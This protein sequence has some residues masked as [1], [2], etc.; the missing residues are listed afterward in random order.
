MTHNR[1]S[2]CGQGG[3]S[4]IVRKESA[5][6]ACLSD[7]GV[8]ARTRLHTK[9]SACVGLDLSHHRILSVRNARCFFRIR[10]TDQYVRHATVN[11]RHITAKLRCRQKSTHGKAE[12]H[13][14]VSAQPDN[15]VVRDV[16]TRH[17]RSEWSILSINGTHRSS[18]RTS[19]SPI[20]FCNRRVP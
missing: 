11:V 16:L 10:N 19:K 17:I 20:M 12:S 7:G 5:K 9:R 13:E 8:G 1:Q 3:E 2:A 4:A 6:Q 18:Q 14:R 15:D